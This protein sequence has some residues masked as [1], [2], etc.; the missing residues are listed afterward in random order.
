MLEIGRRQA[1]R[2]SDSSQ[3]TGSP[4]GRFRLCSSFGA[5]LGVGRDRRLPNLDAVES[6][7]ARRARFSTP[8]LSL[9]GLPDRRAGKATAVTDD[10]NRNALVLIFSILAG[11]SFLVRIL[12][13]GRLSMRRTRR[14]RDP[15]TLGNAPLR[16]ADPQAGR[17]PSQTFLLVEERSASAALSRP[18]SAPANLKGRE[19]RRALEAARAT[20][21]N[22]VAAHYFGRRINLAPLAFR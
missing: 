14:A 16:L 10:N 3:R 7:R 13:A 12:R 9:P 8:R 2:N 18:S 21:R 19:S 4:I 17:R 20:Q 11:L 1:P 6:A 5:G 15:E 22:A